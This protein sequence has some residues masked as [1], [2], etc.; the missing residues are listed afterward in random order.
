MLP[1]WVFLLPTWLVVGL[2]VGAVASVVVAGVF[3]VGGRIFPDPSV[4]RGPRVDGAGRR[5]LEIRDYLSTIGERFVEDWSI[6]GE[7]VAFYLPERHVA[8]TFDAQSFFRLE[9]TS[10]FAVLCEHEMPGNQLGRR[11]P[12]EV[13]KIEPELADVDDPVSEAFDRLGLATDATADAVRDA[14]RSQVKDVHPDHGGDQERFHRLREAYTTAR[15]HA[16][17]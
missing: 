11:L 16:D 17:E 9:R 8:I 15:E 5:R 14:Y 12:F 6:H 4:S 1:E 10:V 3:V 2:V 13:P 7:T